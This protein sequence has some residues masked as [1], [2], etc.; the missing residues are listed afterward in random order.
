MDITGT[1]K[2]SI[3]LRVA[4]QN[5]GDTLL[6]FSDFS[7]GNYH[8]SRDDTTLRRLGKR[9]LLNRSFGFMSSLGLS[10]TV[11][12]SWEGILVTSVP[13]FLSGGSGGVV[14]AFLIGWVGM[15][16]VYASV[17]ELASIAPTAGGQCKDVFIFLDVCHICGIS[18]ATSTPT[19]ELE[20]QLN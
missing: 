7:G 15:A 19:M 6:S 8:S 17:A 18:P 10:C 9:P 11:L 4:S 3:E 12:L 1:S 13:T 14:W 2:E 20:L 16:S 5:N